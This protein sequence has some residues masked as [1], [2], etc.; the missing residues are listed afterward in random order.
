M[1]ERNKM[2]VEMT[3]KEN[4]AKVLSENATTKG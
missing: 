3:A 4:Q 1:I 2:S